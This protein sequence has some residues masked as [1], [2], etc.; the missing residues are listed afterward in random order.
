M[1]PIKKLFVEVGT[2]F[3]LIAGFFVFANVQSAGQLPDIPQTV[4][5]VVIVA[6]ILGAFGFAAYLIR[7]KK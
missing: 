7:R 1:S 6:I 2:I 5:D 4:I 3:V